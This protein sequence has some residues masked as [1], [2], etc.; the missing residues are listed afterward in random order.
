MKAALHAEWTKLRTV[1][2]T[3]WLVFALITLTVG[4]SAAAT[5]AGSCPYAGCGQDTTKLSLTGV[6][7]GQAIVAMLAVLAISTE[8]STGMIRTTL[9]A[10]PRR[11]TML[12]AKAVILSAV[13]L[14]AGAVSVAG[15][16]LAG[17]YILPGRGFDAAHGFARL[18]LGSG[19]T[20]RAVTGSVLYLALIALL[21]LGFATAVRDSA[22]GI[23]AVLGVLYFFPIFAQVVSDPHWQRHLKQISPMTSG[24]TI[25][26]TTNLHDL[27]IS[28]WA[29]LGVLAAWT[30]GALL[31]GGLVLWRRDA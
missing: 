17:R 7:L 21:S 30:A 9:T 20:L 14:V 19:P 27:V 12:A 23:A 3:G 15:S 16:F 26:A 1:P 24:L 28:P 4:L 8:Y 25:Q 18:S 22:A 10:M 11:L 29:G 13:V 5:G 6:Q 31:L 2:G